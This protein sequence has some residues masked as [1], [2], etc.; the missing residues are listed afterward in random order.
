MGLDGGTIPSRSDVLRRGVAFSSTAAG[1]ESRSTRG[2]QVGRDFVFEERG[3]TA[4][5]TSQLNWGV[6]PLSGDPLHPPVVCCQLGRLYNRSAIIE[7][8]L[9]VGVFSLRKAEL[10]EAGFSHLRSLKCVTP[11]VLTENGDGKTHPRW[12]CPVSGMLSNGQNKFVVLQG[13]GHV[14]SAKAASIVC[15]SDAGAGVDCPVCSGENQAKLPLFPS[16]E[17]LEQ[18]REALQSAPRRAKSKR[19]GEGAGGGS[20]KAAKAVSAAPAL[21]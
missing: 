17:V 15:G 13:C 19:K 7:F 2:G 1:G 11:V 8:L 5:Q 18:L 4:E 6:C 9:G 21:L 16:P 14:L 20:R 10:E 3:L 12:A